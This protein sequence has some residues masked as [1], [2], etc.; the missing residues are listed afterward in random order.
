MKAQEGG[1]IVDGKDLPKAAEFSKLDMQLHK[2]LTAVFERFGLEGRLVR[3][4]FVCGTEP[5]PLPKIRCY[6][7]C[8]FGPDDRPICI[9][10][11]Y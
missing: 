3:F 2:E 10:I 6:R 4:E 7:Y 5:K 8:T 9:W 1:I 11:C